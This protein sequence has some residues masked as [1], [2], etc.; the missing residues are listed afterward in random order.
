[1]APE[2][3]GQDIKFSVAEAARILGMKRQAVYA[4]IKAGRLDATDVAYGKRIKASELIGYGIRAGRNPSELV[5]N[6]Q[7]ETDAGSGE[8]LLWV[9][10]GL[11]LGMLLGALLDKLTKE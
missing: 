6:I 7:N 1:M 11:G 9:L 8:L 10:A 5:N 4:A 2:R 3:D